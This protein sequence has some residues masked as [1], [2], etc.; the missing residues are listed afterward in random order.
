MDVPKLDLV[1]RGGTVVTVEG[2]AEQDVGIANGEVVRLGAPHT[3]TGARAIDATGRLV[4]PGGVDP[5][6]HLNFDNLEPNEPAWVD[7]Y[8]SGSE[9][10]LAGGITTVGNMVFVLP[11]E[12][13]A[14]RTRIESALVTEKAIADVFFHDVIVT[15]GPEILAEIPRAVA[16][17]QPSIKIFMTLPAFDAYAREFTRA[18][19]AVG[20]A[21]GIALVHCEDMSTIECCTVMLAEQARTAMSHFADSR[22]VASELI[23]TERA[24]AMC[25]ATGAPTYVVH[26]SSARALAACA[27]ARAEGLPLYVETRPLYLYL[28]EER[29]RDADGGIY[30]AQPPLRT[31]ADREAL[32]RGIADGTIDTLGSDHAP[33]TRAP[34]WPSSTPCCRCSTRKGWP[35]G[36]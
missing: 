7:D 29:Y 5:H 26:L 36:A 13:M 30:V 25:R 34:A 16:A 12:T 3:L 31:D 14:D 32:W 27:T 35:P 18:M 24:I 10:A 1:V 33:W 4:L 21:G 22:P 28:T 23:A 11:W 19:R 17:G 20:E 2:R 15:P 8:T 9:A 6:V